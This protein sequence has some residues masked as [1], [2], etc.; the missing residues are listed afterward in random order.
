MANPAPTIT[1]LNAFDVNVGTVIDFN[2]VGGTNVVRSNKLYVYDLDN[3]LLFT[4]VY[5]STESTSL[6]TS[7]FINHLQAARQ[8]HLLCKNHHVSYR[9]ILF[10]YYLILNIL[11]VLNVFL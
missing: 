3:R 7:T 8:Y 10:Y 5:V 1:T 4:H 6:F 9:L 11:L 2:I